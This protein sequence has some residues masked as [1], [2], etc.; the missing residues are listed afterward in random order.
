MLRSLALRANPNGV[1]FTIVTETQ[2]FSIAGLAVLIGLFLMS[3]AI[4]FLRRRRERASL[5]T[6]TA[7]STTTVAR[8][9]SVPYRVDVSPMGLGGQTSTP[10]FTVGESTPPRGG[11]A[12]PFERVFPGVDDAVEWKRATDGEIVR[13]ARYDHPA[14]IVLVEVDGLNRLVT[15]L[16]TAAGERVIEATAATIRAEARATDIV[17]RLGPAR[18][19]VLMPETNEIV[20]INFTERVRDICDRWLQTGSINLHVAIGHSAMT[21][22][23]GVIG[24]MRLSQENLD[25]ER[26]PERFEDEEQTADTGS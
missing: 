11:R 13:M 19:G 1:E 9:G 26:R 14:T 18:F 6:P 15:A 21:A 23:L 10:G 8:T 20:A 3:L 2:L 17:A 7:S 5:D 25:R 12:A 4:T 22:S 24:A 16:G